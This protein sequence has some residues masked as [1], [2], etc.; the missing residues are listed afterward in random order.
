V[1]SPIIVWFRRELRLADHPALFAAAGSG[2][3]VLPLFIFEEAPHGIGGAS[4][5][6]LHGS[7]AA[8]D[9][10]LRERGGTLCLRRGT[11]THILA[12]LLHETGAA[13]IYTTR[14]YEPRDVALEQAAAD[15][16]AGAGAEFRTFP[17]R[18][19]FEPEALLSGGNQ[20][21]RVFTPFWRAALKAPPPAT[22]LPVPPRLDFAGGSSESLDAFGLLPRAPDWAKGL[23]AAWTPGEE[24]ARARLADF[25]ATSLARYAE[26][27]D[28]L[29]LDATSL[30]SPHLH[31][32]EV[33]ARQVWHAAAASAD[34]ATAR[35]AEAFQ[36]E[37]L[38]R[39][40]AAHQ[41]LHRPS[42]AEAPLRPEF[43]DFPWRDD[44]AG[45]RAWQRGETGY[46]IVDAAMRELWQTGFMANRARM[47][48]ASF[49]TKH[50]LIR[51]QEGAAWF[52]DT[53]VDADLAN[54]SVNWQWVAGTGI[55]AAPYFR[56]FNPVLQARKFDP[57]GDYV[58]RWLPPLARLPAP[59]I[60]APWLVPPVELAAAGVTLGE[61]YPQP[62]V[63]HDA[64]RAR[65]LAAFASMRR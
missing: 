13:R 59:A 38:W 14:G 57:D 30:L 32:G 36:R 8:L 20:P 48:V 9:A 64:A 1:T 46:P 65:A 53:L 39:D 17:G 6:W 29:D 5:W 60:H 28:R 63:D 33:S 24:A 7:L 54:N 10:S 62:I 61:S 52:L 21:Y 42:L 3:P 58:R 2:A 44:S 15:I 55:D 37:L 40:F 41:L 18:L 35:G 51:W 45:L 56:I 23:C 26:D 49:L 19:L 25:T 27:R 12:A 22:P 16:C 50:L 34:G 47:V 4:R 43:N 11:S 31:F